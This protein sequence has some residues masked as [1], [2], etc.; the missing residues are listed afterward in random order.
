MR[1]EIARLSSPDVVESPFGQLEF[2][3]GVPL[4]DTASKIYDALD[5]MRGIEVFLKCVPEASLA[6]F[7]RG[8]R[9][10]GITS[11]RSIGYSD[12]RSNRW[13]G[14]LMA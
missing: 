3:D 2:F 9:S 4:P 12:P 13:R 10:I 7:R 14:R 8:I 11:P 6:A 1:E 5:L